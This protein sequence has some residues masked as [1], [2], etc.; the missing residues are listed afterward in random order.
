MP[1]ITAPRAPVAETRESPGTE[2]QPCIVTKNLTAFFGD[3]PAVKDVSVAIPQ[4][5]VTAIIGPSGCG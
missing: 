2:K 4:L 1:Q 5:A 3:T